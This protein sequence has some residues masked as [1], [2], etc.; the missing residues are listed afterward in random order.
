MQPNPDAQLLAAMPTENWNPAYVNDLIGHI[1]G[2]RAAGVD[3]LLTQQLVQKHPKDAY[4]LTAADGARSGEQFGTLRGEG[5]A[6]AAWEKYM[7]DTY[8]WSEGEDR[9]QLITRYA[10]GV[11]ESSWAPMVQIVKALLVQE[12][13]APA[14]D[15]YFWNSTTDT[16]QPW[17]EAQRSIANFRNT[18]I[19][20]VYVPHLEQKRDA[21][22][23]DAV[24]AWHAFMQVVLA[25]TA[26]P[27]NDRTN[28]TVTVVRTESTEAAK[29]FLRNGNP[30]TS[31]ELDDLG[32]LQGVPLTGRRGALESSS[33]YT[34][35][36]I[37]GHL[38][39][40]YQVPHHRVFGLY[41]L[42]QPKSVAH[43]LSFFENDTENELSFLPEGLTFQ[44]KPASQL[45]F[46]K[47]VE[48]KP[49]FG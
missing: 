33:I 44:L 29:S 39:C 7:R 34:V 18:Q 24:V 37:H 14:P 15:T 8:G 25:G 38:V 46:A 1:Q 3:T 16:P 6:V 17:S 5:S 12:R 13:T 2:L 31:G 10:K 4:L 21:R 40:E 28:R 30:L 22:L 45:A 11:R 41:M 26:F 36:H 43:M 9:V 23:R 42:G 48:D 47:P 20:A 27:G 49:L 35:K 32:S 19:E